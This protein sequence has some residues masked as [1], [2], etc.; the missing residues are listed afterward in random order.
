M[1]LYVL[2]LNHPEYL[3]PLFEAMMDKG[4]QGATVLESTGMMRVLADDDNADMP[5][6]GVFRH[7]YSPERRSSKTV[8]VVLH[9]EQLPLMAEL[10]E[11]VTGGLD[12]PDSGIS[13]ALPLQYVKGIGSKG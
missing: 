1:Q 7:L 6:L 13:F 3:E 10:V 2:V 12:Q 11:Q 5:L 9:D 4:I 8:F